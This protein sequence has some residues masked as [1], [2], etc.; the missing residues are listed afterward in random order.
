MSVYS[1]NPLND[2]YLEKISAVKSLFRELDAGGNNASIQMSNAIDDLSTLR[3]NAF[4]IEVP[5][6]N[7]KTDVALLINLTQSGESIDQLIIDMTLRWTTAVENNLMRTID[8]YVNTAASNTL[9]IDSV[10]NLDAIENINDN[11]SVSYTIVE[12]AQPTKLPN[13]NP[14][15]ADSSI[16]LRPIDY[17]YIKTDEAISGLRFQQ[18]N[19]AKQKIYDTLRK[20]ED[21]PIKVLNDISRDTRRGIPSYNVDIINK[22]KTDGN[23]LGYPTIY[24]YLATFFREAGDIRTSDL[25]D[26]QIQAVD[27][28]TLYTT[29]KNAIKA[30]TEIINEQISYVQSNLLADSSQ[31]PE[32]LLQRIKDIQRSRIDEYI[33]EGLS[34]VG[35]ETNYLVIYPFTYTDMITGNT[36]SAFNSRFQE[37]DNLMDQ[38]IKALVDDLIIVAEFRRN[39]KSAA[40]I[41]SNFP[42][43]PGWH[44]MDDGT[45]MRGDTHSDETQTVVGGVYDSTNFVPHMMYNP[46]TGA[47]YWAATLSQHSYYSSLG[48]VHDK[49]IIGE[50]NNTARVLQPGQTVITVTRLSDMEEVDAIFGPTSTYTPPSSG[51]S[52]G[53]GSGY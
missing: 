28:F 14:Q 31:N 12:K 35:K 19:I 42:A 33:L 37:I 53:G 38:A 17:A 20:A 16:Q 23:K 41:D 5:P 2:L 6:F 18:Y 32:V 21:G 46:Y 40:A 47:G 45:L 39:N 1:S 7:L 52:S 8:Y 50:V 25:T 51:G 9:D 11:G 4:P 49:P 43:P 34:Y 26:E 13:G 22:L 29:T 30:I 10:P 15:F 27:N 24:Q 36:R 48:Y 3:N 44:Y